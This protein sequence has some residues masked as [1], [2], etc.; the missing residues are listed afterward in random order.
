MK[1][2]IY[3]NGATLIYRHSRRKH[4]SV[5]AG[6]I[7]GNFRD[8]FPEPTAH[9]CEHMFFKETKNMTQYQL[10]KKRNKYF[11]LKNGK[12][13][14]KYTCVEF[15]RS[16]KIIEPCFEFTS[17]ILLNTHF[18]KSVLAKNSWCKAF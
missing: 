9:F 5:T 1:V 10:V 14:F 11:S 4:T 17:D 3:K 13:G 8:K 7:L 12:T 15:C 2:K 16:N 18:L 6:F